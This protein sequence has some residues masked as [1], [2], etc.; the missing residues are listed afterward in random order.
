MTQR[1][2][3]FDIG[4]LGLSSG[5]GRRLALD[6][7][8]DPLELGGQRYA[9]ASGSVQA[10]VDVAHMT[11][12]YSLRLRYEAALAGPCVRCLEDA[13]HVV[14]VDAREVD[15]PGGGEELDSPYLD[16]ELLDLRGWAHDALALA[17]PAQIVCHDECLGL[18]SVCG[19]NLNAAPGHAHE[20]A[21]DPRWAKLSELKLE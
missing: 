19:E 3:S 11:G 6:V 16:Q 4:R 21:P 17:L 9:V 20:R 14:V 1:T 15:Q 12:G 7:T 13:R 10:T 18:C 2:D 8:V 5:A